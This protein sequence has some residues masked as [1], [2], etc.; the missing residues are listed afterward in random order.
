VLAPTVAY[1]YGEPHQRLAALLSRLASCLPD[2]QF[3]ACTAVLEPL[4]VTY[5]PIA[6]LVEQFLESVRFR[7]QLTA[8]LTEYSTPSLF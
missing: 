3:L 6:T 8:S 1:Y 5:P 4:A 7:Q 2:D